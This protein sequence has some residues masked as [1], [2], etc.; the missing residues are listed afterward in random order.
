M[1][2]RSTILMAASVCAALLGC[3]SSQRDVRAQDAVA[4]PVNVL[5]SDGCLSE[6]PGTYPPRRWCKAPGSQ[7]PD[8]PG[9]VKWVYRRI[10]VAARIDPATLA[11]KGDM[12]LDYQRS[13]T[14]NLAVSA[15]IWLSIHHYSRFDPERPGQA[16]VVETS[17]TGL[18]RCRDPRDIRIL[19][20]IS[21]KRREHY[22]IVARLFQGNR[23]ISRTIERRSYDEW[24]P[25]KSDATA[26][27]LAGV[28]NQ[29]LEELA[30]AFL[31]Q[32]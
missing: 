6:G 31:D 3:A 14:S 28:V 19:A 13:Y 32:V 7:P 24:P 26:P 21:S 11:R 18:T 23:S 30:A 4:A 8:P 25:A 27:G 1:P 16:R 17:A 12:N 10:C 15:S 29:E 22:R 9:K 2:R 5:D 20:D